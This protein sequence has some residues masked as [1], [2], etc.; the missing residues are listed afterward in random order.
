MDAELYSFLKSIDDTDGRVIV[1]WAD[2]SRITPEGDSGFTVRNVTYA[3]LTGRVGGSPQQRTIHDIDL[4]TIKR[5]VR[6]LGLHAMYVSDNIT[7]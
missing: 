5:A 2:E 6:K 1:R 4:E 7:R 3:V